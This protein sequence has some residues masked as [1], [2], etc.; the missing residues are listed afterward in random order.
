MRGQ[1]LSVLHDY[2]LVET[3]TGLQCWGD[4]LL[5]ENS[6]RRLDSIAELTY[7]LNPDL[8]A[9]GRYEG[10]RIVV[11]VLLQQLSYLIT[12]LFLLSEEELVFGSLENEI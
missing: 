12:G 8:I 2:F 4:R 9:L 7:I 1:A 3:D 10:L 11:L 5:I 6:Q